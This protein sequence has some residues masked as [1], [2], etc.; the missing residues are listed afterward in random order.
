ME[1]SAGNGEITEGLGPLW[2]D[3]PNWNALQQQQMAAFSNQRVWEF[4]RRVLN[5]KQLA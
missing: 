5:C 3:V 4:M 2:A 1:F